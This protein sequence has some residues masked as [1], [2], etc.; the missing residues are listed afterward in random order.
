LSYQF[1]PPGTVFEYDAGF[2][3]W[4]FKVLQDL[5]NRD[6]DRA[7]TKVRAVWDAFEAEQFAEQASFEKRVLDVL[8]NDESAAR[9][10]LTEHCSGRA[11][12]A[13]EAARKLA[14]ELRTER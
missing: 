10:R 7:L 3:W 2:A 9:A 4:P 8:S 1:D 5:V 13:I 6:R 12:T 11:F 14:D